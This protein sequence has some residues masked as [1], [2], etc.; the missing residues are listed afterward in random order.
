LIGLGFLKIFLLT[1]AQLAILFNNAQVIPNFK[2]IKKFTITELIYIAIG[3]LLWLVS[4]THAILEPESKH[5]VT[6]NWI[7]FQPES[8][9]F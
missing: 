1:G 8:K 3:S 9:D 5:R 2:P 7:T 4:L 6:K